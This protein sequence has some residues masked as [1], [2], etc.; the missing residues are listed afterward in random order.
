MPLSIFRKLRLRDTK[1]TSVSLQLADRSVTY[2]KGIIE[3]V[4][5]K[6]DKFIFPMDFVVLDM[7]ED[8]KV[9]LILGHPFLAIGKALM[10]VHKGKLM[11]RMGQ[12]EVTF[13]V[14]HSIKHPIDNDECYKMNIIDECVYEMINVV[15][16]DDKI[17]Y[18]EEDLCLD[19]IQDVECDCVHDIRCEVVN[20]V[21]I[22]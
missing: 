4:L 19:A 20:N 6:V 16:I 1:L 22:G 18:I 14:C 17:A 15:K 11:L 5:V 2:P 3:D 10:D 7:E 8:R 21:E 13:N 12:E 9:P